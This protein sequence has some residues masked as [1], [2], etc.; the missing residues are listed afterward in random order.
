MSFILTIVVSDTP[1]SAGHLAVLEGALQSCG[2]VLNGDP[3][4]LSPHKAADIAIDQKPDLQ[5]MQS[6]HA[7][8][9]D[10]RIDVFVS[11]AENRRKKLLLADMDSTIVTSETLDDI[12][13]AAGL[14]DQIAPITAQA[15]RGEID[16]ETALRERVS[17]LKG[18]P[19]SLLDDVLAKTILSDGATCLVKTMASHGATC[20]LVS[21]GFTFF[22]NVIASRTGFHHHHGNVLEVADGVLTGTVADPVLDRDAKYDFLQHHVQQLGIEVNDVLAVGDGSND[23]AMLEAAGLGIGY[24]PKPLLR[25]TLENV[26]LY[27]G[28]NTLLYAQGYQDTDFV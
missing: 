12:A 23:L 25:E 21:G 16:F 28:L 3:V 7:L 13:D 2:L 14:H 6:L 4:W 26:V 8:L 11:A 15:M 5:Q 19:E 24:H 9:A 10:D 18:Q 27:G 17:L 20:V 1:L 22:T